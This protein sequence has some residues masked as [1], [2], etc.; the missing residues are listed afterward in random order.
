MKSLDYSKSKRCFAGDHYRLCSYKSFFKKQ[1][2][3]EEVRREWIFYSE[4]LGRI[5]CI[6]CQLFSE[7]RCGLFT[8]KGFDDWKHTNLISNHETSTSHYAAAR[9]FAR[10]TSQSSDVCSQLT[11]QINIEIKYWKEVLKRIVSV[12]R[13]L[14]SRG[15]PFRGANCHVGNPSNGNYLGLL[16]LLAEYDTLLKSHIKRYANKGKGHV[17]YLSFNI[18]NEFIH[19]LATEVSR[20]VIR[21]IEKS[22]YFSM[23]IDST[24]DVSHVD[25]LTIV[26]RYVDQTGSSIERFLQFLANTGH[27]GKEMENEVVNFLKI[28]NINIMDCRGQSYDTAKNMSGKYKGLQTRIKEINPLAVYVPCETHH[29]NLTVS[30]AAESS[31]IIVRFFL[32]VQSVYVFFS[33]STHRWAI[34]VRQLE[35][36]LLKRNIKDERLLVPKRLSDTRWCARADACRAIKAGYGSFITSLTEISDNIEE[37]KVCVFG[38]IL[39]EYWEPIF[40][41][42]FSQTFLNF[43]KFHKIFE[44]RPC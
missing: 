11:N 28:K 44:N 37:K 22:K 12:I 14:A 9:I 10:R 26:L 17:S 18:A 19:V 3:G 24:P 5:F 21:E 32:F 36:D 30:H 1:I 29:L 23:I 20:I 38:V 42:I 35:K 15:L 13:F 4:S 33:G 16:E 6:Y 27:K 8:D 7:K 2:N 31:D 34:L 25:Q 43:P 41:K 39:T 40:Q